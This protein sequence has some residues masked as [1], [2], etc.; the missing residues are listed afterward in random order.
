MPETTSKLPLLFCTTILLSQRADEDKPPT[1]F[2][3]LTPVILIDEK[4]A[5]SFNTL[6][7]T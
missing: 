5:I 1:L 4:A 7:F 6:I 3:R 2:Q